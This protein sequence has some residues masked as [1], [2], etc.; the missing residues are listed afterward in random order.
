[1]IKFNVPYKSEFEN[2]YVKDVLSGSLHAGDGPY[3]VRT[4]SKLCEITNSENVLLTPSCTHSLELAALLCDIKDGDE[5]IMPS[6]TFVSTAN[7]FALRGAKIVFTDVDPLNMNISISNVKQSITSKTKAIVP[8]HYAGT[9]CEMSELLDI[10]KD[11]SIYVIEDAA[12]GIDSYYNGKHLGTIGD[13]GCLSFHETKNIHCGEGGA[14]II[15]NPN[16]VEYAEIIRQKG[17]NRNQ[18]LKG[19]VDKYTWTS[20]G[21]SYLLN[22]LS[23]AFL[24]GQLESLDKQTSFRLQLWN[25]YNDNLKEVTKKFDFE[26]LHVP[27]YNRHNAHIFYIKC[28][29]IEVRDKLI[30]YLRSKDIDSTFHYLPLHLSKPGINFGRFE[31]HDNFTTKGSDGIARLP[32]HSSLSITDVD[33]ICNQVKEFFS[34]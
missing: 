9:S 27:D 34:T 33:Y 25:R 20:L 30:K 14:L 13:L 17:T 4:Q 16:F 22:E 28:K 3:G 7:A 31:G 18:F 8:V 19:M 26:I 6:Y 5:V 15:N 2:T 32:L 1:M 11:K 21:S 29:S 10:V 23:S 24:L 12:Q